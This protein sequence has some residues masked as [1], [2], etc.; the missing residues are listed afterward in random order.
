[1]ND[2]EEKIQIEAQFSEARKQLKDTLAELDIAKKERIALES[3]KERNSTLIEE[4]GELLKNIKNEIAKERQEWSSEKHAELE[5]I[6]SKKDEIKAILAKG[7]EL[8]RKEIELTKLKEEAVKARNEARELEI[9]NKAEA[10]QNETQL[11]SFE[12]REEDIAVA[13]NKS[14]EDMSKFKQNVIEL[15]KSVENL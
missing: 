1:M 5:V 4:Q 12:L 14:K 9:K 11:R 8:E 15:I 6:D 13:A 3:I 7:V 10:L 2:I